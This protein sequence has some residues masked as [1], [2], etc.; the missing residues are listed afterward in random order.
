M[1]LT[2]KIEVADGAVVLD[3]D[4]LEDVMTENDIEDTDELTTDQKVEV[5]TSTVED[6][7]ENLDPEVF[8]PLTEQFGG[9]IQLVKLEG[10]EIEEDEEIEIDD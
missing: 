9:M 4:F 6:F 1:I 7:I 10:L 8:E 3:D 2:I 5:A